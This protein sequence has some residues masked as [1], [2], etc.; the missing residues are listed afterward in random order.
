[1]EKNNSNKIRRQLDECLS[2]VEGLKQQLHHETQKLYH[3]TQRALVAE[4]GWRALESTQVV[5]KAR[6]LG[7]IKLEKIDFLKSDKD[8]K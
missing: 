7:F 4:Q 8:E 5:R 3:E 1:V 2:E 6:K